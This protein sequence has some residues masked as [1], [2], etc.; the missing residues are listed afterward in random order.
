MKTS[1]FSLFI[2]SLTVIFIFGLFGHALSGG[3]DTDD[4]V[5]VAE[6]ASA[7]MNE[8]AP[9]GWKLEKHKGMPV[10]KLE[11]VG[12]KFCLHMTSDDKS[13]FGIQKAI[14]VDVQ[15]Y[16]FLNWRWKVTKLPVGG[17]VRKADT[18]DQAMQ[19]Y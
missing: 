19:L 1:R 11:K 16:P 9:V 13:S 18:D 5:V 17:D 3:D 14:E 12:D 4:T 2:F 15:E 6:F 8:G 7:D 10:I